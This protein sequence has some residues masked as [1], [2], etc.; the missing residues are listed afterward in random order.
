MTV[1]AMR[2]S[3]IV[4]VMP[5]LLGSWSIKES[6]LFSSTLTN[7]GFSTIVTRHIIKVYVAR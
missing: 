7:N 3:P 2:T 5:S 4:L 6:P 1:G